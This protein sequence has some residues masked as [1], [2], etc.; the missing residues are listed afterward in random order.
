[1][2]SSPFNRS[3]LTRRSPP[4]TPTQTPSHSQDERME[5]ISTSDLQHWMGCIETQ[6]N[7]ICHITGEGKLNSDQKLKVSSLCRK[8]GHNVGQLACKYQ[9]LKQKAT[10]T[11]YSLQVLKEHQAQEES[12]TAEIKRTIQESCGKTTM[13]TT[14]FADMVKKGANDFVR[15][16]N[17]NSVA[18]YPK[19]NSKSSD[20]TKSLVQKIVCPEEMKIKVR[21]VRRVRNGGVII[22]TNSKDDVEKLMKTVQSSNSDLTINEPQKRKPRIIIIGVPTSIPESEVYNCIFEQNVADKIPSMTRESFMSSIKTSHK[23]GR[24][25]TDHHNLIIEVSAAIRKALITQDRVFINWTSCPVRDFTLVT[26]CFNCHQY[27]HAAK[28][29]RN[30]VVTCG[31]CATEGHSIKD[32]PKKLDPPKCASCLRFNKPSNH[33]TG[34]Q[35]CPAKKAA[36]FRYINSIDFEGA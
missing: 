21:G 16:I 25:D 12:L 1:M 28:F 15:P 13:E 11:H 24:K 6:L 22:S 31:H 9:S 14:T 33:K 5:V 32:C 29:C 23:S 18:I 26:R 7:E 10:Q 3:G 8:I 20:D 30:P 27:G 34:E 4:P 17:V 36:E 2:E 19:D 35:D